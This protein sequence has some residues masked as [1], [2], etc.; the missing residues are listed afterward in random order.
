[1]HIS[2]EINGKERLI[3]TKAGLNNDSRLKFKTKDS[4]IKSDNNHIED[5]FSSRES[6]SSIQHHYTVARFADSR[7]ME[8]G[9]SRI[10]KD[11]DFK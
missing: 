9:I 2:E 7:E 5:G 11:N 8:E 4:K 10:M 3:M 1:L 6:N